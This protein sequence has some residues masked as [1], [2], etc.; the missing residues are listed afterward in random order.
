HA[1]GVGFQIVQSLIAIGSGGLTGLGLMDGRQKL[2]FLPE[3][4]TDFIFAVI[5]E[6]LGLIGA[7]AV[8][9]LFALFLVRGLRVARRAPDHFGR[10]MATGITAMVVIEALINFSVVTGLMPTKGI[11]LPFI[12]YGSS[13]L[14]ATLAAT[15]VLLNI[16][17][18]AS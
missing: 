17:Q 7:A 14:I 5:S 11:A 13:S 8:V 16:S 6:E 9:V 15:G 1:Q 2:F 3:P 4:H 10:L 18:H 12:S